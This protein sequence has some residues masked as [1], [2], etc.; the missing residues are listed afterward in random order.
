[1]KIGINLFAWPKID[2]NFLRVTVIGKVV[3]PKLTYTIHAGE[4]NE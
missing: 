2:T 1:M 3:K 4:R